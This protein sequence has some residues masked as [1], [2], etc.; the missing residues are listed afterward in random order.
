[1]ERKKF[2]VIFPGSSVCQG[3]GSNE[4]VLTLRALEKI[5]L[6]TSVF[7]RIVVSMMSLMLELARMCQ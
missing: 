5:K 1:M 6:I 3:A 7:L 2:A 4:G